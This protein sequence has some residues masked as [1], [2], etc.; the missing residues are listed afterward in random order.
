MNRFAIASLLP[1]T[2]AALIVPQHG[3][4]GAAAD[5]RGE[6]FGQITTLYANDPVASRLNFG[7][8]GFGAVYQDDKVWNRSSDVDFGAYNSGHFTVGIEGGQEGAILDLGS[9]TELAQRYGYE[10]TVGKGQGYASIRFE[11]GRLVILAN[12][13]D[14]TTQP[15]A[16]E[17]ALD[18]PQSGAKAPVQAGHV[19]LVRLP[20][21]GRTVKLLVLEHVPDQSVTFRWQLIEAAN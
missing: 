7:D 11:D 14:G 20:G 9:H 17:A 2:L 10:E 6:W 19:Y 1:L 3:M 16:E 8:G 13:E 15:L 12:Y 18:Q 21:R 5:A 4:D